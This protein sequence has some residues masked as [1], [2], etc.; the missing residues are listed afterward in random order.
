MKPHLVGLHSVIDFHD[1]SRG[2][3]NSV[4]AKAACK[5]STGL[6]KHGETRG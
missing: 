1:M 5:H 3:K 2:R 4:T 6:P